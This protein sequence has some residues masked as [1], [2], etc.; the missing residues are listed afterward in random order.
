VYKRT[1]KQNVRVIRTNYKLKVVTQ[2]L[3]VG[4]IV[5][6]IIKR[7]YFKLFKI[8]VYLA[9]PNMGVRTV[10]GNIVERQTKMRTERIRLAEY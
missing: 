1:Y 9:A 4:L 6:R 7:F 10:S 3:D 2:W 5:V 8:F